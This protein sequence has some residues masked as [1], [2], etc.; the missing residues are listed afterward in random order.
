MAFYVSVFDVCK[1]KVYDCL[2]RKQ[3]VG[4]M[5]VAFCNFVEMVLVGGV[6]EASLV[7]IS[8]SAS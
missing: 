1:H 7:Y 3:N 2:E 6:E 8:R 4:L 5:D